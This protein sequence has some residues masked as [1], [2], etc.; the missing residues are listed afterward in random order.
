MACALSIFDLFFQQAG[1]DINSAYI[2]ARIFLVF[3]ILY[4]LWKRTLWS[5]FAPVVYITLQS[6]LH[7]FWLMKY[8]IDPINSELFTS[9]R[10]LINVLLVGSSFIALTLLALDYYDY[11]KRRLTT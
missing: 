10:L 4:M 11:R 1:Q 9:T 7:S 8:F 6:L 5:Y 2:A 3:L